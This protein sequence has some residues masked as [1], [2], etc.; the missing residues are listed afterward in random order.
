MAVLLDGDAL[1]ATWRDEIKRDAAR[2]TQ[3]GIT[4]GLA[5][6]LVGGDEASAHYVSRK[7]QDCAETGILSRDIRLPETVRQ[8]EL[9]GHV[10]ELNAEPTLHGVL[11]QL[12]LP[13]HIDAASIQLAVAPEK[14][15]DG[16]HPLNL[17]A[18]VLGQRRL[19]PCTPSAILGLL[20]AY[21]VPLAGRRV[22]VI[23]RGLLVGRTLAIMLADPAIDAIP[24]LLHRGAPDL[25]AVTRESDAVIAAAGVPDL[26][27]ADMLKPGACAVGVGITYRNGEMISDIADDVASVAGF[28]TPRHGSVGPLTR[29][30]LLRNVIEAAGAYSA[31]TRGAG[32]TA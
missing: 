16:L 29:A 3:A 10:R 8:D 13:A 6:I 22:A 27:R 4:P 9:L 14:D 20:Q 28:L 24:T 5:T 12:P 23:G 30:M 1:A 17:G 26:V 7:H 18:L 25:A 32:P 31:A 19:R 21:R 15:V 2:L 11:V